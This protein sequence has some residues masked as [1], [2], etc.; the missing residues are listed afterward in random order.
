MNIMQKVFGST[1]PVQPAQ[2]A[3]PTMQVPPGTAIP[4][5]GGQSSGDLGATAA[6]GVIPPE[7][8]PLD[9][10]KDLWKD[11]PIDPAVAPVD[12]SIFGKVNGDDLMKAAS[13]LDFTKTISPEILAAAKAGGEEGIAALM[14]AINST[15]QFTY[16]QSAAATTKLI[17]QAIAKHT[18]QLQAGLPKALRQ[19]ATDD[20]I[21]GDP[22]L[23]HPAAKPV[24]D[25]IVAQLQVK[26]PDATPAQLK[27]QAEQYL[28]A[29]SQ[30]TRAKTDPQNDKVSSV[31][32]EDWTEFFNDGPS[33]GMRL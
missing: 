20:L 12:T 23:S 3:Q 15:A 29:F 17:E 1:P 18:T 7:A 33:T 2:P 21:K 32:D 19:H 6:N 24:L 8:A 14:K 16:A 22:M 9:Q 5:G 13:S 10:F 27:D 30:H 11:A 25:G 26:F 28:V 4:P 31:K